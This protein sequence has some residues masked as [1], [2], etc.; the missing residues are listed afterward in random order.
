MKE[1]TVLLFTIALI[2]ITVGYLD[3]KLNSIKNKYHKYLLSFYLL[4]NFFDIVSFDHSA[5][6]VTSL[7]TPATVLHPPI[8]KAV[9]KI[10]TFFII[11]LQFFVK[12][13]FLIT[14]F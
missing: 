10:K 14:K 13:N 9:I 7:P 5:A 11:N 2:F 12:F 6:S 8:I 3:L 4:F 1:F